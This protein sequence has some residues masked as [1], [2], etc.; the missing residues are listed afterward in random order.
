VQ[1]ENAFVLVIAVMLKE[2]LKL[3]SCTVC[4]GSSGK[5]FAVK[6]DGTVS[7]PS[8]VLGKSSPRTSAFAWWEVAILVK[9]SNL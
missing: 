8:K 7:V 4:D 2:I 5:E 9:I 6:S 1:S 3:S